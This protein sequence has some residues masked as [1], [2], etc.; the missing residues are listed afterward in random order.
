MVRKTVCRS[1]LI[2]VCLLLGLTVLGNAQ[3]GKRKQQVPVDSQVSPTRPQLLLPSAES[4]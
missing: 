1:I 3:S 4:R 2:T